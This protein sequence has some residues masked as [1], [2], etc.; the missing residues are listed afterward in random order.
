MV[1][2]RPTTKDNRGVF[3]LNF[4]KGDW[5]VTSNLLQKRLVFIFLSSFTE[6]LIFRL[7]I[8]PIS[9]GSIQ[10]VVVKVG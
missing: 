5:I 3:F 9:H 8:K 4:M 2:R 1:I 10:V 6:A 7:K